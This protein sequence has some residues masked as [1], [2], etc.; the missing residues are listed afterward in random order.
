MVMEENYQF[1]LQTNLSKYIGQWIA[2]CN[3]EIV[4]H[5][6]DM[7]KVFDEAIQKYPKGRPLLARIPDK[8]AMIF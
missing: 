2:I 5:G 4:S 6:P 8:S 7:K 3:K 1:Y